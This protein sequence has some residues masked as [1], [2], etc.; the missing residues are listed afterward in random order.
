MKE[1][2]WMPALFRNHRRLFYTMAGLALLALAAGCGQGD[3]AAQNA[4]VIGILD[5]AKAIQG[6]P[7]YQQVQVL[8]REINTIQAQAKL[9]DTKAKQAYEQEKTAAAMDMDSLAKAMEQ[10]YQARMKGKQN[11]LTQR[12]KDKAAALNN[13]NNIKL[14]AYVKELDQE[15][16]NQIFNLQVKLRTLQLTSEEQASIQKELEALQTERMNKITARQTELSNAMKKEMEAEEKIAQ[17]ELEAYSQTMQQETNE[18]LERRNKELSAKVQSS[19]GSLQASETAQGVQSAEEK[20]K[21]LAALKESILQDLRNTAAQI[22]Q[23]RGLEI[24]LADVK[25][26]TNAVDITDELLQGIKD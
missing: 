19:I 24:I 1:G 15:Y 3:K 25:I 7:Q 6:H 9:A 23:D 21:E 16:Q 22:A 2:A 5:T 4:P 20:K 10:Q 13:D 18:R 12:L 8:Q 17:K 26:Y 14:D 11:E